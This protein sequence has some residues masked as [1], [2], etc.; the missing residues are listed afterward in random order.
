MRRLSSVFIVIL[1]LLALLPSVA[2]ASTQRIEVIAGDYA[3]GTFTVVNPT[4]ATYKLAVVRKV[5]VENSKGEPVE[6]FNITIEPYIVQGWAPRDEKTFSY[7]VS[8]SLDVPPGEYYLKIRFLLSLSTGGLSTFS[9]SI[10]LTVL[11]GP[12][13]FGDVNAYTPSGNWPLVFIGENFVVYSTVYNL[14]HKPINGTASLVVSHG[15]KVY[16]NMSKS[17]VFEPG[18]TSVSFDIKTPLSLPPGDY[19]FNYTI[20]TP[21]GVFSKTQAFTLSWG[22]SLLSVSLERNELYTGDKTVAYVSVLSQREIPANLS[23]VFYLNGKKVNSLVEPVSLSKGTLVF[24]IPVFSKSPGEYNVSVSLIVSGRVIGTA[25]ANYR[26]IE[27]P[28]ISSVVPMRSEDSL[29]FRVLISN[30]GPPVSGIISYVIYLSNDTAYRGSRLIEI[31]QGNLTVE[32]SFPPTKADVS[33]AF[34]FSVNNHFSSVNG[35]LPRPPA[36]TSTTS[37]TSSP[38]KTETPGQNSTSFPSNSTVTSTAGDNELG[39]LFIVLLVIIMVS[40][41]AY[42]LYGGKTDSRKR[43][44]RK[45]PKRRSPLGRFK[46]PKPPKFNEIDSLPKKK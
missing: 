11:E 21:R 15:G 36:P 2:F 30:P 37:T 45:G 39:V 31:P 25:S 4:D 22:A 34:N 8:C 41:G 14:G 42:Y 23:V 29:E 12:L 24:K 44:K 1:M 7:N 40:A 18:T 43:R 6:G 28:K 20:K 16:I 9:V 35:T 38:T 32:F 3:T 10:P 33:Y 26:V 17:V 13:H 19:V 5:W 46:R 27:P